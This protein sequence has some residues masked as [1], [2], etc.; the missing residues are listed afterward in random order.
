MKAT[1]LIGSLSSHSYEARLRVLQLPT[2]QYRQLRV[3][4]I[5]LHKYVN[6]KY[7]TN[8]VLQLQYK[9]VRKAL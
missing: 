5:Q 1:K 9:S 8:F 6:N 7:D 3:D 2:L 4:M